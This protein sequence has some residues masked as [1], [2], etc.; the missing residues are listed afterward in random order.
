M[1]V[2]LF[3]QSLGTIATSMGGDV[4]GV[5]QPVRAITANT[6]ARCL[7]FI[8]LTVFDFAIVRHTRLLCFGF[9]RSVA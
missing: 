5:M 4:F 9:K 6:G 7:M 8:A 3:L 2:S 1:I